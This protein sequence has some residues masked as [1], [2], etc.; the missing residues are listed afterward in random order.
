M[1]WI[2]TLFGYF[3]VEVMI[4]AMSGEL[5]PTA[6]RSTASTLRSISAMFAAVAGLAAEDVLYSALGSHSAAISIICLSSLLAI[7]VVMLMLRETSGTEL[8]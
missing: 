5:F 8:I 7:P 1:A 3:A 4:N 6:C 2:A